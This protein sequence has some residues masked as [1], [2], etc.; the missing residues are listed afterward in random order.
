[1]VF[2]GQINFSGSNDPKQEAKGNRSF[3]GATGNTVYLGV[4]HNAS[5]AESAKVLRA[6]GLNH[7]LNLDNGGSTA[8]WYNGYK[9]G[10]G[11]NLPNV[12]LLI[13]K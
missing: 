6:L 3:L 9:V 2:N 10:P 7:A 13:K 5:V 8:L 12:V 1:L 11:R 4:V